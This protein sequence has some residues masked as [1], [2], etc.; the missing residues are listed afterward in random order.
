[1]AVAFGATSTTLA[2]ASRANTDPLEPSGVGAGDGAVVVLY[3]EDDV[4][5]TKDGS[6]WTLIAQIDH[7]A[8]PFDIYVWYNVNADGA[9]FGTTHTTAFSSA[10]AFEVSG[11]DTSNFLDPAIATSNQGTGATGTATGI[12]TT[13]DNTMLVGVFGN[14]DFLNSWASYSAPLVEVIDTEPLAVA[15]GLQVSAGASGNKT[16]T[17]SGGGTLEWTA[18]LFGIKEAAAGTTTRRYSLPLTGLG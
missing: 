12:T 15:N 10:A 8:Q 3:V 13:A 16:A 7:S 14:W 6:G 11:H 1:M 5:V 9:D 18:M 4:S 2:G 17:L